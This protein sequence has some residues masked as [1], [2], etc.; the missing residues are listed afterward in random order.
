MSSSKAASVKQKKLK[1]LFH[2]AGGGA[3]ARAAPPA[4]SA[5]MSLHKAREAAK[6]S[7]SRDSGAARDRHVPANEEALWDEVRRRR[8]CSAV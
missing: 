7:L 2:S 4:A 3:A 5:A 8:R 6:E 1:V